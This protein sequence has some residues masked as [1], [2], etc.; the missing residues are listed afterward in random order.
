[1]KRG[2]KIDGRKQDLV[3]RLEA[4]ARN[5]N[6]G[7]TTTLEK[8][9]AMTVP[10]SSLYK[11]INLGS[12]IPIITERGVAAYLSHNGAKLTTIAKDMYKERYLT[13][14]RFAPGHSNNFFI[15]S[16]CQA[17]MK[18]Q[19]NYI[20]DVEI[21]A[22]GLVSEAQCECAAGMGPTAHCKHVSA[23][24]HG[25]SVYVSE[26]GMKTLETCTQTLQQFHAV[27]RA[28][29]GSPVKAEK[30]KLPFGD[31]TVYDP[32]PVSGRERVNYSSHF[33][34]TWKACPL[35]SERP[36]SH[37]FQ[38][39]NMRA[40]AHDH[41]YCVET[42]EDRCLKGLGVVS[43]SSDEQ[44]RLEKVTRG[45]AGNAQ[46]AT[47][48][49]RRLQSSNFG[50]VCKL[51]SRSDITALAKKWTY[52]QPTCNAPSIKHG[53]K[54][55]FKALHKFAAATGK[56]ISACGLYVC[57]T[58]PFLGASPDAIIEEEG[59]SQSV[60]EVKCPFSAKDLPISEN[61]VPYLEKKEGCYKLKKS[62]DYFYQVQGQMLCVGAQLAYFVVYTFK[63]LVILEIPKDDDFITSMV[64]KLQ[65]FFDNHFKLALLETNLYRDFVADE[66][67]EAEQGESE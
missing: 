48:R 57:K 56:K 9:Y 17:Q 40:V 51:T 6:F 30:L 7:S 62:H 44:K 65:Q 16:K 54:Y 28:Y 38:P 8:E 22:D 5:S 27:K 31:M 35:V 13:H 43:I 21:D 34:N 67:A 3:E 60:V 10:D 25:L 45:Q 36:V 52:R 18:T 15:K 39:V 46:W 12:P 53:Q 24:L 2:A 47:E 1:M 29:G 59:V 11:D 14:C 49:T 42:V 50:R 41:D 61:N 23:V 64:E 66:K 32:R 4:Y 55:E 37:L 19:V 20:V 26:G 63:D 58:Y 33:F